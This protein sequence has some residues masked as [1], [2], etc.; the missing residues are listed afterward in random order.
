[1]RYFN[2]K[3]KIKK[4][5]LINDS[6]NVQRHVEWI[7]SITKHA[8]YEFHSIKKDKGKEISRHI[9]ES[10]ADLHFLS[11]A[12]TSIAFTLLKSRIA[13]ADNFWLAINNDNLNKIMGSSEEKILI[14]LENF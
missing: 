5:W 3:W 9:R 13:W 8:L 10:D 12:H 2:K 6:Q 7:C 4:L 11:Q 14:A 1:M